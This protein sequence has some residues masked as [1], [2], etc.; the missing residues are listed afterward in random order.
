MPTMSSSAP[1]ALA[2]T[3]ALANVGFG[4]LV[5]SLPACG[6]RAVTPAAAP[7]SSIVTTCGEATRVKRPLDDKP[8]VSTTTQELA[9]GTVTATF[10]LRAG[11]PGRDA[12]G[13]LVRN[14]STLTLVVR[15]GPEEVRQ[16]IASCVSVGYGSAL[17]PWKAPQVVSAMCGDEEVIVTRAADVLRVTQG[18]A[19]LATLLIPKGT[20]RVV[21]AP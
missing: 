11:D 17:G 15:Y 19:T 21:A 20:K 12:Q 18:T 1:G 7:A 13:C 10:K 9:E 3:V 14:D 2:K 16:T 8:M 5:M 4:L 6:S